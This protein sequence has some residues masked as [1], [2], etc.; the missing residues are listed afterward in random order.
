MEHLVWFFQFADF[1]LQKLVLILRSEILIYIGFLL[2]ILVFLF[3]LFSILIFFR[4]FII[5][6]D[7]HYDKDLVIY[8]IIMSIISFLSISFINPFTDTLTTFLKEV[9][10]RYFICSLL[11]LF[12]GVFLL[13][14]FL[15]CIFEK[16]LGEIYNIIDY[17]NNLIFV[18]LF[19]VIF[20]IP[21]NSVFS[22]YLIIID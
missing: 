16:F 13:I 8:F 5:F 15:L 3:I 1:G 21:I 7:F 4:E 11:Y 22:G 2:Y 14:F 10:S 18:N 20:S 9:K 19:I 17:K 12:I 6:T